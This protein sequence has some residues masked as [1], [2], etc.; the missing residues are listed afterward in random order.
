[1]FDVKHRAAVVYSYV[2]GLSHGELAGKLNVPLGT[3]KS[4]IRLGLTKLR[5]EFGDEL[6]DFRVAAEAA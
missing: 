5:D 6:S 3:A 1:M 4:R 2:F